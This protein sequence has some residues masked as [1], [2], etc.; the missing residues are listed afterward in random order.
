MDVISSIREKTT[1]KIQKTLD[2]TYSF[3]RAAGVIALS[4][5][6]NGNIHT[7]PRAAGVIAKALAALGI[8]RPFPR[9]AGVIAPV[10][11]LSVIVS[12]FPRAAG[13][14]VVNVYTSH[15]PGY[16]SPRSGDYR[17]R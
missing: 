17:Y 6:T 12:S 9:A 5:T 10:T 15:E 13:V 3:P 16:F 7:F 4:K 8:E 14:I 11:L 2:N 1:L